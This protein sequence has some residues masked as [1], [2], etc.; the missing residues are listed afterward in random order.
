MTLSALD[1]DIYQQVILDHNRSPRNFCEMQH[2][3]LKAEGYNPLCGDHLWVYIKMDTAGEKIQEISFQGAGCAISKA[4]ASM[5]TESLKGRSKQ[6]AELIFKEFHSL[7][8]GELD[9]AK[10]LHLGKLKV[11]AG[12]GKYPSRVKCA[13]LAWHTVHEVLSGHSDVVSTE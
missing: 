8:V 2:C 4:S 6:E 9:P 11:F 1:M 13:G 10:S 12:I 3:S 7:I 5:M